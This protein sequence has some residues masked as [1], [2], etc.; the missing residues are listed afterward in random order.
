MRKA[1]LPVMVLPKVSVLSLQINQLLRSELK[2]TLRQVN[3]KLG[4]PLGVI[5]WRCEQDTS[6]LQ[7]PRVLIA[8]NR[9]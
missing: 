5:A 7:L 3:S 8:D 9:S 1:L 2:E 4:F 6:A